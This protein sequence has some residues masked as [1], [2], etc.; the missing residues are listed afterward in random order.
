MSASATDPDKNKLTYKWWQYFEADSYVGKLAVKDPSS[1]KTSFV[2][3]ADAKKGDTIH[4]ICEVTDGGM[5]AL[6]RYQRVIVTV[7]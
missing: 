4:V 5:P 2:V 3:P 7:N 6:T 1:A